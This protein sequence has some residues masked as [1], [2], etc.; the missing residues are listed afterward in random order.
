M[1]PKSPAEIEIMRE[2][3]KMLATILNDLVGQVAPGIRPK[4]I[5][6][7]CSRAN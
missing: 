6:N 5:A 1:N 7:I 4:D 3:G 2:G